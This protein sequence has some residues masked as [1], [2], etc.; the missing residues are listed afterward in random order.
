[1]KVAHFSDGDKY[2]ALGAAYDLHKKMLEQGIESRFFLRI[3]S[4][5]DACIVEISDS[6]AL[7]KLRQ[8]INTMY[9]EQNRTDTTM[10]F[11]YNR[12]GIELTED[13][14]SRLKEYDI[15]H[16]HW[17]ARFLNNEAIRKIISL[18][19]PIVWTM[20]DFNP[21]TGGCHYPD[22]CT[23]FFSDCSECPQLAIKKL[24]ITSFVLKDKR[25]TY[26]NK[27]HVVVASNWLKKLVEKSYVFSDAE[28]SL[29]PIGIDVERFK[30]LDRKK[31]KKNFGFSE[32][33]KIILMGAQLVKAR[34]KGYAELVEMFGMLKEEQYIQRLMECD[35]IKLVSFG[36]GGEVFD[37]LGISNVNMGF[38][39]DRDR[40]CELY[41]AADVFIFPSIQETFGMTA[42][43]AMACGIPVIA[44]DV[45]A[46][47]DIII[48]GINGYKIDRGNYKDM[49]QTLVKVLRGADGPMDPYLCR[50]RIVEKYS[51]QYETDEMLNLYN[52]ICH[53]LNEDCRS[54]VMGNNNEILNLFESLCTY[55]IMENSA[56]NQKSEGTLQSI[57]FPL[58]PTNVFPEEKIE[59]L[60]KN[61]ILSKQDEII[62][63]GAGNIGQRTIAELEK[64]RM[65]IIEIWDTDRS[66]WERRLGSYMVKK[67]KKKCG[68]WNKKIIVASTKCVEIS[69]ILDGLKYQLGVDYI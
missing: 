63:Y 39:D 59:L 5:E 13:V 66:K 43:E 27:I 22:K 28:C 2:G 6:T 3:K 65:Q 42:V 33:T 11:S 30:I 32:D 26:G 1:M 29:I 20:H 34:T 61:G 9:F 41:N 21:M 36:Y 12:L 51:L 31:C 4:R 37:S 15:I 40:L 8:L 10:F 62:I 68:S 46:M 16:F 14:L 7:Y 64:N 23:K 55:E 24:N 52:Q 25:C 44:Y 49:A 17:I 60:L 54:V 69:K 50:Q 53:N 35:K 56:M 45:C 18:G 57:F 48:N 19:K 67:P 58:N 47:Q 38:I